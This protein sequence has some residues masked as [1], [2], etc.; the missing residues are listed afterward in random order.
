MAWERARWSLWAPL[1]DSVVR[2][3]ERG[4]RRAIEQLEL[5]GDERIL[6]VAC[7]TGLDL[8]LLPPS[9]EV[10]AVDYNGTMLRAAR[11]RARR[12]GR[13]VDFR[14]MDAA[15]LEFDDETFDVV[16]LHLVLGVARDPV[17]VASEAGRV[18]RSEGRISIYDKFLPYG[19]K[20]SWFRRVLNV[21]TRMLATD[22]NRQLNPIVHEAQLEL[23]AE[24]ASIFGGLFRVAMA[25]KR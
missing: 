5:L 17:A 19:V 8:E 13:E 1:Y 24:E 18:L 4:R 25:R 16:L 10:V 20:P 12:L 15:S 3:A 22:I 2:G 11:R 6:I 9:T 14:L 7:G 21:A 23:V